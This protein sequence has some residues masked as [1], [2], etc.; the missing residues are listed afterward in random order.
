MYHHFIKLTI[1]TS[2]IYILIQRLSRTTVALTT[3]V[4]PEELKI[5]T[6]LYS[7]EL[8]NLQ[9]RILRIIVQQHIL[10]TIVQQHILRTIVQQH[11]LRISW[12]WNEY[13]VT[14]HKLAKVFQHLYV[15]LLN[16][17]CVLHG[18]FWNF[19]S[20]V[21]RFDNHDYIDKVWNESENIHTYKLQSTQYVFRR[22]Q[23]R[24]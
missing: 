19:I 24:I 14:L 22:D 4:R 7:Y 9:Q 8:Y 18:T 3:H 1:Y 12:I 11:I 6:K 2:I 15:V 5:H 20:T 21:M 16:T 10:R 17:L 13:F 23:R